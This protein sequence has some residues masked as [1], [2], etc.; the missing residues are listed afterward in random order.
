MVVVCLKTT[1]RATTNAGLSVYQ[2]CVGLSKA[3]YFWSE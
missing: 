2:W 1:S 3:V